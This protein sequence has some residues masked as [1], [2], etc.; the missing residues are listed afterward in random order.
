MN[1]VVLGGSGFVGS[2]V[3]RALLTAE[4]E[5]RSVSAPRLKT[6][7]TSAQVVAA[8]ARTAGS[9]GDLVDTLAGADIVVLAAGSAT[10]DATDSPELC[11]ANALLPAVVALACNAAGVRRFLHL[12]SAAVQGRT[13]VLDETANTQPFSPYSRS[14]ALGEHVLE[15]LRPELRTEL[16]I[17]RAT[18]VQGPGRP[19]T[20]KLRRIARSRFAS[21]A[22]SGNQPSP[23]SAV[24]D[25]AAFC[26]QVGDWS[27]TLPSRVLQPWA[28]LSVA[29][30]LQLAGGRWPA[31][32][33]TIFC[34]TAMWAG[35][36]L[37]R[38]AG[39]RGEGA[40]RRL[41]A[42][43][44]GQTVDDAWAREQGLRAR[45]S[46]PNVLSVASI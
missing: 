8:E 15:L 39:G 22:G 14:K 1:W 20:A 11:G 24:D 25:L 32:L 18:S 41:E 37:S 4:Q 46:L 28:G 31:R 5:V 34:R 26:I 16:V 29:E 27:G 45:S 3:V 21:V 42:M 23:V 44:F 36:T 12:S 7:A 35:F 9:L 10:P 43:W 38:L 33:P 40:I 17:V 2:A 13:A 6:P 30:V 19:T